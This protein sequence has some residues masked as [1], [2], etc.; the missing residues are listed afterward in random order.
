MVQCIWMNSIPL[1]LKVSNVML[2][3]QY[4]TK[5]PIQQPGCGCISILVGVV[6]FWGRHLIGS[7][8]PIVGLGRQP[9][10]EVPPICPYL[11]AKHLSVIS[12]RTPSDHALPSTCSTQI[13]V[14][15]EKSRNGCSFFSRCRVHLNT[16]W[17]SILL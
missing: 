5:A 6:V 16:K 17:P 4:H 3:D 8:S 15:F 7:L 11:R 9:I 1:V 10:A 13:T 2:K 12:P 14:T